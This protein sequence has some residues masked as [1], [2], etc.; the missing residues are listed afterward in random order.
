MSVFSERSNRVPQ[1]RGFFMRHFPVFHFALGFLSRLAC[2][3]ASGETEMPRG[4]VIQ[5]AAHERVSLN[6]RT[7]ALP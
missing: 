2:T 5:I 6:K 4:R 7:S 1:R 3:G